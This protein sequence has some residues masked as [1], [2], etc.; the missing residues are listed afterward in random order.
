MKVSVIT[1]CYN[2]A[3]TLADSLISVAGQ[4]GVEVEHILV[5]GGSTDGTL[6]IINKYRSGLAHVI[7]EPDKGI[8]DAMNKGIMLATGDVVGILNSDD[9]Y[10][11]EY[12]LEKV[13]NIF[14]SHPIDALFADLVYVRPEKTDKVV[15]Y[16]SGAS[17]TTSKFAYG[18]MPPHPTFFVKRECYERYGLFRTDFKIAADFDLL[19]RFLLKH[20]LRYHYL[21]EVI[22]KM[23]TGGAS[24]RS[25]KSNLILNREILQSCADNGVS[26][27]ILKVYTKY[28]GKFLQYFTRPA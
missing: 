24:T 28:F 20:K 1:V 2:S 11:N 17:F 26:T 14:K 27:N 23:R 13:N 18:W 22:V 4:T 10:C 6:E 8:Y 9:L 19:V 16:Y 7:T 3:E 5:D 12:V 21:P 15:R 25:L